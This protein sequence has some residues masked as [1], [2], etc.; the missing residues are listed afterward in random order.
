M[1]ER[2]IPNPS[3]NV[4]INPDIQCGEQWNSDQHNY[5]CDDDNYQGPITFHITLPILRK[6]LEFSCRDKSAGVLLPSESTLVLNSGENDMID[7]FFFEKGFYLEAKTGFQ[8]WPGTRLM[9]EAFICMKNDR[10]K[11][12]QSRLV[13]NDLT[14][15]ELG[16]GVGIV[17]TCLAAMGGKVMV[18]DLSVLVE[19]GIRPNLQRNGINVG[20]NVLD[21]P[22]FF[23]K[24]REYTQIGDGWAQAAA[25]DWREPVAD[26][27]PESTTSTIDLII[28][29]DCL[30]LRKLIDP[31]LSILSTLFQYSLRR[32]KFLFTFQRRNM[33]GV[34]ISIE[35][36]LQ[37]IEGRG[38]SVECVAWRHVAVDGDG[39]QELY[40][41]EVHPGILTYNTILLDAN[42]GS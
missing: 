37:R 19:N 35:E 33:K 7:P 39:D 15:L 27:L 25:V 30:F 21:H 23:L 41:F 28:A 10:M 20:D 36:L 38:W 11:Y 4:P 8:P 2:F 16:A 24:S 5:L 17:G 29:C 42:A 1:N 31:L 3:C 40:L 34:F 32:P 22:D 13:N 18:T 14:I 12:W 26:Q 6:K 9:V